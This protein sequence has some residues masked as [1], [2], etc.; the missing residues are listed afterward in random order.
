LSFQP[1]PGR[2][3]TVYPPLTV[4]EAIIWL[5]VVSNASRGDRESAR[6]LCSLVSG[7]ALLDPAEAPSSASHSSWRTVSIL[8][9]EL[10]YVC[11][12]I[13]VVCRASRGAPD[14]IELDHSFPEQPF[15]FEIFGGKCESEVCNK[16]GDA[17]PKD[18][19]K[20]TDSVAPNSATEQP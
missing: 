17:S 19:S 9:I 16:L 18:S 10:L 7:V 11:S 15:A 20:C 1:P 2:T 5:M 3:V 14:E 4:S 13:K 8:L 6:R 12:K